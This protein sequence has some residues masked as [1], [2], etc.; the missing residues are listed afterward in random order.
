VIHCDFYL[1]TGD[2]PS[3]WIHLDSCELQSA[4]RRSSLIGPCDRAA[5]WTEKKYGAGKPPVR[6]WRIVDVIQFLDTN[7]CWVVVVPCLTYQEDWPNV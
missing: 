3:E 7:S 6:L 2:K 1:Q 4:V 5:H